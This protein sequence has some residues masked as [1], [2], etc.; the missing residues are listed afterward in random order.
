MPEKQMN[1]NQQNTPP[2]RRKPSPTD[3]ILI[4]LGI[5][6]LIRTPWDNMDSFYFLLIFLYILCI[7]LRI[8]NLRREKM[9]EMAIAQRKAQAQE[10]AAAED[11]GAQE[12]PVL[13]ENATVEDSG[14]QETD[15]V[16][17][18]PEVQEGD[19]KPEP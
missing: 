8:A 3:I 16:S 10:N 5:L 4:L 9:R 15:A 1:T 14:A 7:M 2:I 11:S 18:N 13:P 17:E 6:V 19:G 12:T